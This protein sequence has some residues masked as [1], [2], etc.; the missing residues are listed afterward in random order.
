M[1]RQYYGSSGPS[2]WGG[3]VVLICI[4]NIILSIVQSC[5]Q[6]DKKTQSAHP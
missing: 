4:L 3:V 1:R 2:A 6:D 5:S